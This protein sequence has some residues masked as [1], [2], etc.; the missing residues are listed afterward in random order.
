MIK[1]NTKQKAAWLLAPVFGTILFV[2]L[3]I[4]AIFFYPGGS[5]VDKNAIGFSLVNNYWCNL[6]NDVAINGEINPAKPIAMAGLAVLCL[7]LALFWQ[8]FPKHINPGKPVKLTIQISGILAMAIAFLLFTNIDHDL[9]TNLASFFGILA[10]MGTLT[11]LY[12][13]KWYGLFV[14]GLFNFL[15]VGLNAYVY[16]DKDLIIYLPVIQKISFASFLIWVC[17]I[18]I[19]LYRRIT[20]LE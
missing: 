15:L 2:I 3:Y 20:K 13:I 19:N 11:G 4:T 6:L 8:L 10:T 14:F 5:Q 16:Y 18:D 1:S 12:K 7:T 9:V 17:S